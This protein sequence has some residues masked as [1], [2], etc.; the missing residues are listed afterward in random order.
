MGQF[1][2]GKPII[3]FSTCVTLSAIPAAIKILNHFTVDT[4]DEYG[5]EVPYELSDKRNIL[6]FSF[7]SLSGKQIAELIKRS[8][9][10]SETFKDFTIFEKAISPALTTNP[11]LI[12]DIYGNIDYRGEEI[13]WSNYPYNTNTL[14]SLPHVLNEDT[15]YYEYPIADQA[16]QI[17]V[18]GVD[19][20]YRAKKTVK[21]MD[22]LVV[23]MFG[24]LGHRALY[25]IYSMLGEKHITNFLVTN[26]LNATLRGQLIKSYHGPE[27][28]AFHV[29]AKTIFETILSKLSVKEKDLAVRYF[30][31]IHTHHPV[32]FDQ[33]CEYRGDDENWLKN[34]QNPAGAEWLHLC[35]LNSFTAILKQLKSLKTYDNSL[36]I[37]KSDH[38]LPYLYYEDFPFNTTI[39]V[40]P[41][42]NKYSYGYGRYN[43]TLFVKDFQI[44]HPSPLFSDKQVLTSDIARTVCEKLT[45]LE[46][47]RGISGANL[48]DYQ[49]VEDKPFYLE[50]PVDH[51]RTEWIKIES[52][53]PSLLQSFQ[54]SNSV[55]IY[56]AE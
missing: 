48:L 42:S 18:F 49:E 21:V 7:D 56:E 25:R 13:N 55:Q 44:R 32:A 4:A 6:I 8:P 41:E 20:V 35:G 30:H 28:A 54:N 11:S 2:I 39:N 37:L 14:A 27:W 24:V 53:R 9:T 23:R 29:I 36:I 1:S 33:N 3:I 40:K 50:I 10:L 51:H 26:S 16:R 19:E 34:H 15:Y 46:N 45:T 38:G 43:A 5:T 31:F 47:C 22:Y 12:G 17:K 52:R